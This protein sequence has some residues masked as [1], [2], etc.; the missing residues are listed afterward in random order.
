MKVFSKYGIVGMLMLVFLAVG[1]QKSTAYAET[2]AVLPLPG[3]RAYEVPVL[4]VYSNGKTHQ[5]HIGGYILKTGV[6]SL[7]YSVMDIAAA[8][9]TPILAVR[10][11]EVYENCY[12]PNGGWVI[13][14]KH[15]NDG[16][17][18][19]YSYYG[20]MRTQGYFGVGE[21]VEKGQKI[22]EVGNSG[23]ATGPHVHFEWSGHDVYC[24]FRN[25]GYN[26][27]VMNDS[28]ASRYP[29][30]HDAE[31]TARVTGTDGSLALNA[32]M[33]S[34][35]M[36]LAI[37]EGA[38]VNVNPE[39]SSS[40]WLYTT[41]QN[42]SGYCYYKYL[43]KTEAVK[44]EIQTPVDNTYTAYVSG[45]DGKLAINSKKASGNQIATV[46]E[47]AKVLIDPDKSTSKWLYVT[48]N[49]VSGYSYYK[50][51]TTTAPY[52]YTGTIRNTNGGLAINATASTAHRVGVIP[53]GAQVT[54]FGNRRS[55][56]WVWVCYNGIFG[57]SY[58]SYIK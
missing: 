48:Y 58:S 42:Q 29:H 16:G 52:S 2:N 46:P 50:Y 6:D 15:V 5:S 22:G 27:S 9:G 18:T 25:M 49:G 21:K 28:G 8:K 51:L 13:I 45:T 12:Y 30:V 4:D 33:K 57:Y 34:G 10:D 41:Y 36:I 39:K 40:T 56:K 43:V 54:V 35:T 47:C 26:I 53:E 24:E 44:E 31:Y 7:K 55:G 37:P 38:L 11:G 23:T 1:L 32:R 20:H 3:D 14:L 19:T 17:R